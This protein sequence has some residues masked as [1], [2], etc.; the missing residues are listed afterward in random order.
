MLPSPFLF[1]LKTRFLSEPSL[2]TPAGT[3][4]KW[5]RGAGVERE[6]KRMTEYNLPCQLAAEGRKG[7]RRLGGPT[8]EETAPQPSTPPHAAAASRVPPRARRPAPAP[9]AASRLSRPS[10]DA[11]P[12]GPDPRPGLLAG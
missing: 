8:A 12:L 7:K 1:C 9:A 4:G 5:Q 2:P 11:F 10:Q 6:N 3:G